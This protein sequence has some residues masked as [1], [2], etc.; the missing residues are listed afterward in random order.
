MCGIAGIWSFGPL[1][2]DGLRTIAE[3][4]T[5]ALERRGPDAAGV[6][7][8]DRVG[9]ALG[10]RRLAILDPAARADQPMVYGDVVVTYN[11][12]LYNFRDLRGALEGEGARFTTTSD[13]EV[14]AA[15]VRHWGAGPAIARFR[16]MFALAV[17]DRRDRTLCLA[18][19]PVGIKPLYYGWV[20][21][22]FGFG[23]ELRALVRVPGFAR[24][25][26]RVT[27]GPYLKYSCVPAP[28]SVFDGIRKLR[29]GEMVTI[30]QDGTDRATAYAA[31]AG[32]PGAGE[33]A[34]QRAGL[35]AHIRRLGGA[36]TEAVRLQS[37]ADVPVGCFL[38]GGID[39]SLVAGVLQRLSPRP[40]KT[41]TIGFEERRFD[42]AP[43]ARRVAAHLGTDHAETVVTERAM[44]DTV[45]E[46]PS[47]YDEPFAD[48][49][50]IVTC[51]LA[52]AARAHVKVALSGDGGDEVFGGYPR[53]ARADRLWRWLGWAPVGLRA[54]AAAALRSALAH[55]GGGD[56]SP[57]LRAGPASRWLGVLAARDYASL[58]DRMIANCSSPDAFLSAPA[59]S[60]WNGTA[61]PARDRTHLMAWDFATYLPDDILTKVDRASMSV[62]LEV[63]VPLLDVRFLEC[64]R[65]FPPG[66]VEQGPPKWIARRLLAEYLPAD[67]LPRRKHGFSAPLGKWLR[68]PLRDWA[69]DLLA[70]R[71]LGAGGV[72]EASPVRRLWAAH[73]AGRPGLHH[74]LWDVLMFEAWRRA[75]C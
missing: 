57:D 43:R 73:L 63:R 61:T 19:D 21:R 42:E 10:H 37:V 67:L 59:A 70:E 53:Y 17:W 14:V 45:T 2:R 18:R 49:S 15:A 11:G 5:A 68:G 55:V 25:I 40:I 4:M 74:T 22:C 6:W 35:E 9:L 31:G 3:D 75:W 62:G 33:P 66:L 50:Q 30:G 51:I 39:S 72:F 13:T 34:P 41:F 23:S 60:G 47:V 32:P 7:I 29:P 69:E 54:G 27:L 46:L 58:Y 1:E 56:Q 12:E 71:Q 48:S 64:A 8:D 65:Q 36:L 38:S 44:L 52:R 28:L 24:S 26:N 20:G 16:G